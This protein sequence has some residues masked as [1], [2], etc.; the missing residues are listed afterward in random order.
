MDTKETTELKKA[1]R[2]A[3]VTLKSGMGNV[4]KIMYTEAS[5]SRALKDNDLDE[6]L[7]CNG[8]SRAWEE[9][10]PCAKCKRALPADNKLQDWYLELEEEF[11]CT[12]TMG[13]YPN[14]IG[15]KPPLEVFERGLVVMG[16]KVK[17]RFIG[18]EK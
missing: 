8:C 15:I 3:L 11:E 6:M 4:N 12:I 5:L 10:R 1:I 16:N 14:R 13:E 2:E 7:S 9:N 17:V 18:N